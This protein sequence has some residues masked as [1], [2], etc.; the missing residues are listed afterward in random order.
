VDETHL[1]PIQRWVG[2][3]ADVWSERFYRVTFSLSDQLLV[4]GIAILTAGLK[5]LGQGTVTAY[6]FSI[7]RDLAF[8][9]SNAHLLSLL[10]PWIS[11]GSVR[12]H[13]ADRST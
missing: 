12:K 6:H 4:T 2:L 11:F 9:S 13:Q 5:M 7:I 1:P 10:V 3:N 8:F